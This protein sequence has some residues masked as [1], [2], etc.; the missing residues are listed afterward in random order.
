MCLYLF[1]RESTTNVC[2]VFMGSMGQLKSTQLYG[3]NR[4]CLVSSNVHTLAK[5]YSSVP[6]G[7]ILGPK[8]SFPLSALRQSQSDTHY[9]RPPWVTYHPLVN[10]LRPIARHVPIKAN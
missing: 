1:S 8:P 7:T 10:A 5:I 6:Q 4:G 2:T 3:L 9:S